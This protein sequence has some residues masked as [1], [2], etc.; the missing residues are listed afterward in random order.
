MGASTAGCIVAEQLLLFRVLR[1]AIHR[2]YSRQPWWEY[3]TTYRGIF[4]QD[5]QKEVQY[6]SILAV[7]HLFGGYLMLHGLRHQQPEF[8]AAGAIVEMSDDIHDCAL[9][10]LNKWPFGDG[11]EKDLKLVAI[12]TVHHLAS[13]TCFVP[14]LLNGLH[15][16][17]RVQ[18]LGAAL[19]S[20]G[21]VSLVAIVASRTR[22]RKNAAHARQDAMLCVGNLAF[23]T[24]C[25]FYVF[26]VEILGLFREDYRS[27][28]PTM[29]KSFCLFTVLMSVFNVAIFLEAVKQTVERVRS[30]WKLTMHPLR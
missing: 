15:A 24:Y 7:H 22:N 1:K 12:M 6:C 23:Y 5:V 26:P 29:Q 18:K 10:F 14:T 25:R 28:T 4:C 20:A 16:N 3:L 13:I 9:M 8:W 21:G 17:P 30:G 19:L 11:A 2:V 27:F